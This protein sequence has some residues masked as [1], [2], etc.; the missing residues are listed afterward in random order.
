MW[1][2]KSRDSTI[3]GWFDFVLLK[4]DENTKFKL[5][6]NWYNNISF[7]VSLEDHHYGHFP[8]LSSHL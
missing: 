1:Y 8:K 2:W 6:F 3:F 5:I 4:E 7:D